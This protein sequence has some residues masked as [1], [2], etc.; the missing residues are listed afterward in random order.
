MLLSNHWL[1]AYGRDFMD[2][3]GHMKKQG[4]APL[5]VTADHVK[6]YKR[7][8]IEE[9]MTSATVARRLSAPRASTTCRRPRPAAWNWWRQSPAAS[10]RAAPRC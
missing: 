6:L 3:V 9:G 7:V 10:R 4:I 1:K 2:I 5:D 8:L